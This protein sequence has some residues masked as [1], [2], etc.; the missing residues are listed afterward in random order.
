MASAG[1]SGG[2][3]LDER[4]S[5]LPPHGS[6]DTGIVRD[7]QQ[8][9]TLEIPNLVENRAQSS[10]SPT[11][12]RNRPTQLDL[13]LARNPTANEGNTRPPP[14]PTPSVW[15]LRQ[16]L[17]ATPAT[18]T[19]PNAAHPD[20]GDDDDDDA[21]G[22]ISFVQ[23]LMESR[24]PELP[25]PGSQ[26][27]QDPIF[28]TPRDP[29]S[30]T[31]TRTTAADALSARTSGSH[32]T[33]LS[34]RRWS[35]LDGV[36]SNA[37]SNDSIHSSSRP[38]SPSSRPSDA[39]STGEIAS[40]HGLAR[41]S[42]VDDA[43]HTHQSR[44]TPARSNSVRG[45]PSTASSVPGRVTG[46]RSTS[47]TPAQRRFL[48]R[49]IT[50]AL[51]GRRSDEIPSP[52]L[53]SQQDPSKSKESGTALPPPPK[54]EYVKLPGTKGSIMIKAVETAKK[55]YDQRILIS[56]RNVADIPNL[57]SLLFSVGKMARKWNFLLGPIGQHLACP[58]HSFCQIRR[59]LWSC[60]CRVTTWSRS[61]SFSR[62][63]YSDLNQLR[64]GFAKS[65]LGAQNAALLCDEQERTG[66]KNWRAVKRM[67]L[68]SVTA[69]LQMQQ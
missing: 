35:I 61:S 17:A 66:M 42:S 34:R 20:D 46:I 22:Q 27:P 6:S 68:H 48:P 5:A 32:R 67:A 63:T 69:M 23:A 8:P 37:G 47:S 39:G 24:L 57:A 14:S 11:L 1:P 10:T 41:I 31:S 33:R 52:K 36:F 21:D 13:T 51:G 30:P 40:P 9:T 4:T 55:R 28:I 3:A 56:L 62:T 59:A 53:K 54:L 26:Q 25:P 7:G 2:A 50:N 38:L 19:R 29:A 15:T 58:G 64:Y 49:I 45:R 18:E 43:A 44:L 60:S 65:G 16:A 12:R